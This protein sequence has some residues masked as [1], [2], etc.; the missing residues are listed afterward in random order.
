ML[1]THLTAKLW[2]GKKGLDTTK[3]IIHNGLKVCQ[4]KLDI[5]NK[6]W[7]EKLNG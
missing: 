7:C 4:F 2:A 6:Y 1:L 3:L 5:K